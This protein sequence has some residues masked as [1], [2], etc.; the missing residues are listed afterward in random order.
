[1]CQVWGT[2]RRYNRFV[3]GFSRRVPIEGSSEAA[4]FQL[5]IAENHWHTDSLNNIVNASIRCID[6]YVLSR[7]C[8]YRTLAM[9]MSERIHHSYSRWPT[10]NEDLDS[11]LGSTPLVARSIKSLYVNIKNETIASGRGRSEGV[12]VSDDGH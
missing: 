4:E 7:K 10:A 6:T 1:M 5:W 2:R 3:V 11:E 8:R 12:S 9:R